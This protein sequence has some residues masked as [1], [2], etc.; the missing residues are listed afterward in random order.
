MQNLYSKLIELSESGQYPFHMPGHK[1]NIES[2]PLKGA[3]R[4]DITEI[5]D[6]DNLHDE[7]GI[8]LKA[9]ERANRLYGAEKTF[10][11]VNGSS[12]GV[13]SAVS[14]AVSE[15]G[16]ILAARGSHKS[17]YHAAYLRRLQISYLPYFLGSHLL[18]Y[19]RISG[20]R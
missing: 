8:I 1:R 4:C 7:E 16:C 14:A 13:L 9:E 20:E 15:G 17:F 19:S 5:D 10:F 11:L 18:L 3:F 6:F 2:T 12:C